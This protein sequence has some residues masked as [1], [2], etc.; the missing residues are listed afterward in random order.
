MIE[1]EKPMKILPP[2]QI[3][4]V[5]LKIGTCFI[6]EEGWIQQSLRLSTN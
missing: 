3:T 4:K 1:K 5:Q 6:T 2:K